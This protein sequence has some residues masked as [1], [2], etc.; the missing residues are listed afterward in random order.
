MAIEVPLAAN[1]FQENEWALIWTPELLADEHVRSMNER[2]NG[3]LSCH[4]G[5]V[6]E[7]FYAL[8]PPNTRGNRRDHHMWVLCVRRKDQPCY[9]GRWMEV[10]AD[11]LEHDVE[12]FVFPNVAGVDK[13][14]WQEREAEYYKKAAEKAD[15]DRRAREEEQ[16]NAQADALRFH[17]SHGDTRHKQKVR[18][19]LQVPKGSVFTVAAQT[20]S[21]NKKPKGE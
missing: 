4:P 17:S 21:R 16:A 3:V 20:H 18:D 14:T 7:A 11:K 19:E 13:R 5:V 15:A 8:Q 12:K 6:I 10:S 1:F 2:V 9:A